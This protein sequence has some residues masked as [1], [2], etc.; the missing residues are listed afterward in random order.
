MA[1]SVGED[2]RGLYAVIECDKRGCFGYAA[3]R[4]VGAVMVGE[5]VRDAFD[6]AEAD[7]WLLVGQ[8]FC[9]RHAGPRADRM[10]GRVGEGVRWA[11]VANRLPAGR[12]R[13]S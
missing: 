7:G 1:A 5:L 10:T 2:S 13:P 9:P 12:Q 6:M 3:V 11:V 8:A 4:P